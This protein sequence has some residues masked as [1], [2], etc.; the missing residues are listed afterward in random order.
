MRRIGLVGVPSSAGAHW[1]GQEKAPAALREAGLVARLEAAGCRAVDHGDLPRVRFQPDPE[2]RR[3]QSLGAVVEVTRS[4]ADEVETAPPADDRGPD[5][6]LRSGSG[7][8]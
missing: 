8:T 7:R 4:V 3:A 1:P 5:C 6:L 2:H